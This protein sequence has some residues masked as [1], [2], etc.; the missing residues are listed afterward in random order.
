MGVVKRFI[1]SNPFLF[2]MMKKGLL[3]ARYAKSFSEANPYRGLSK[4]SALDVVEISRKG[5]HCYFGYYDK[6]PVNFSGTRVAYLDVQDK[7][8]S[9]EN[10]DVCIYDLKSKKSKIIGHTTAWNWQQGCMLQWISDTQISYNKYDDA[11][12][13]Y[14][15]MIVDINDASCVNKIKRAAYF[16][17]AQH[18]RFLSLNFY[19]LDLY[20]KGYGYPYK[21]DSFDLTKDGIWEIDVESNTSKLILSLKQV[22]DYKAKDYKNLQ[23]YINHVAYTPDE[24]SIIFIHRW[25]VKGGEFV[26]RL[27]LY[28]L[29][30]NTI[31]TLLD[32][33]HVSHYC[34]KDKETLLIY[35]TNNTMN[36][37][38]MEI[39]IVTKE[40]VMIAGL[41]MEDGHPS[42]S[43][44]RKVILTDTYPNHGRKQYV[45]LFNRDK[46]QLGILDILWSP[47]RY[48]N[49]ERCD[50]HPRWSYD[51]KYVCIDNTATGF[52]SLKLYKVK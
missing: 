39:N 1:K 19:R 50:L 47:F 36:K 11:S 3:Y 15:T 20:A 2:S 21:V 16:Y 9:G 52:R 18:T 45:F 31:D 23:H 5:H 44:D 49:D 29:D 43:L 51:N 42:Y 28:H 27:L 24:K 37:G 34:W 46:H 10:A 32:Y 4:V 40:D 13:D 14:V 7:A 6:S 33:G 12:R 8:I 22:I 38:Y 26:S 25:Q 35:A 48:F 41:P 30:T 17:N